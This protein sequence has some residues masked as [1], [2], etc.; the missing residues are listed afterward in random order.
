MLKQK[1]L[2]LGLLLLASSAL[3]QPG[4][5]SDLPVAPPQP[6]PGYQRS[7]SCS[8]NPAS[9]YYS[10]KDRPAVARQSVPQQRPQRTRVV[11]FVRR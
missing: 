11:R 7:T 6:Q 8:N 10:E 2:A 9:V 4:S 5:P 3:A 1:T